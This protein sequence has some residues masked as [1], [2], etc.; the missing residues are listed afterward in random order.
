LLVGT[1]PDSE[2]RQFPGAEQ[3]GWRSEPGRIIRSC[4]AGLSEAEVGSW[5]RTGQ[6][7]EPTKSWSQIC[8][9]AI[10]GNPLFVDGDV[11]L[12]VAEGRIDREGPGNAFKIPDGVLESLW[13]QVV[14]LPEE[15]TL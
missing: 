12:V 11:R 9:E 15:T 10:D 8:N 1:Y 13:R 3:L 4:I 2:V 6:E 5:S 7:G 14:K